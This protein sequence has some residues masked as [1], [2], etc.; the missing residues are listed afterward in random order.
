MQSDTKIQPAMEGHQQL[1]EWLQTNATLRN[2]VY[3]LS[4][5][6]AWY[7]FEKAYLAIRGNEG[8][9]YTDEQVKQLPYINSA[10]SHQTEWAMR[11]KSFERL[12]K[13]VRQ[14]TQPSVLEIGCGNGWLAGQLSGFPGILY[15]GADVNLYELEQA[16]NLFAGKRTRFLFLDIF[17]QQLPDNSFDL[18]I[19]SAVIQYFQDLSSLL[20]HLLPSLKADGEVH[21][22]DSPIY[23]KSEV[24]AAAYRSKQYFQQAG[25]PKMA[26]YY[27]HHT[28]DELQTYN[29][30][31][32]FDP[33]T[34]WQKIKQHTGQADNPFPWII[35]KNT[36]H[37]D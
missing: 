32:H 17:E 7:A 14:Y 26:R 6:E 10:H 18:I 28:W 34:L 33:G 12:R 25:T 3:L 29:F 9:I 23:K 15:F 21:I 19:L 8:R 27:H 11:A 36:R 4:S 30:E 22:L 24:K 35:V 1:D 5:P 31:I 13:Y 37:F 20:N 2:G 16:A